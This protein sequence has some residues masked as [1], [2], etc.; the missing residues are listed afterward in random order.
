MTF[1]L[2]ESNKP[3]CEDVKALLSE[4][5]NVYCFVVMNEKGDIHYDYSNP[6]LG[7]MLLDQAIKSLEEE[8]WEWVDDDSGS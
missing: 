1:E 7:K 6:P 8:E 4:H 5:F 2:D 3:A